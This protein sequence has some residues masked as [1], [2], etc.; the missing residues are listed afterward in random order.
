MK[1][2]SPHKSTK[3]ATPKFDFIKTISLTNA[4][5][6]CKVKEKKMFLSLY[7]SIKKKEEVKIS[8]KRRVSFS[9]PPKKQ[10]PLAIEGLVPVPTWKR[11]EKRRILSANRAGKAREIGDLPL[12]G[13]NVG[14]NGLGQF[15]IHSNNITPVFFPKT[16]MFAKY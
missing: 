4:S 2:S 1:I 9:Q 10:N 12:K 11:A 14:Q 16:E 6:P 8:Q 13:K 5:Q 15:T 7:K 3:P